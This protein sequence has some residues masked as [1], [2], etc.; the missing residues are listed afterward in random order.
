MNSSHL[1]TTF[2]FTLAAMYRATA[3]LN[4]ERIIVTRT[5][6]GRQAS[7]KR[8]RTVCIVIATLAGW[9]GFAYSSL[10]SA[11][12]EQELSGQAAALKG[13]QSKVLSQRQRE[14]SE[15]R[16]I[17][18]L[19]EQLAL[20]QGE[21][22][23]LAQRQKGAEAN[24]VKAEE[25]LALFQKIHAPPALENAPAL[26]GIKPVPAKQDVLAAQEALTQ[27][28]FGKL[29]ADGVVGPTTQQAIEEFQRVAGLTVTGELHGL[30]LQTLI[31]SA[32][33]VAA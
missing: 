17:A 18:A 31:R 6:E 15:A 33:I 7:P 25:Q 2:L 16:E 23:R 32:K 30:T 5:H 28:G 29:K 11:Q 14:D 10:T 1:L 4:N 12:L 22:Q 27:L 24:L 8:F 3:A 9:G 20:A 13:Y 26:R 19:R 21:V